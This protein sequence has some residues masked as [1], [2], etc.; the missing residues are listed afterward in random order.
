MKKLETRRP[1]FAQRDPWILTLV[2]LSFLSLSG[3]GGCDSAPSVKDTASTDQGTPI[4]VGNKPGGNPDT[5]NPP[6]GVGPTTPPA[7]PSEVKNVILLVGSGM[8]PQQIGEVVQYRRLRKPIED[9]LALEQ[10]LDQRMMGM[11]ATNSYLDIVTDTAAANTAMA[12]GLKARNNTVG[13]DPNGKPCTTVLEQAQALGKGTGVVSNARLSGPGVAPYLAHHIASEE[14]NEIATKIFADP[15][16]DVL[17]AGGAER[18]LPQN[19]ATAQLSVQDRAKI[20][21]SVIDRLPDRVIDI[22]PGVFVPVT[23]GA[24]PNAM[25]LS[26]LSECS[27]LDPALDGASRREDQSNLIENAKS[28]GYQFVCKGAALA[29][30]PA[31]ADTKLL[32]LFS[33]GSFPRS[34]DRRGLSDLPSLADLTRKAIEV[35]DKK[36]NGFLLVVQG[37]LTDQVARENDAGTLLQE[38]LDFDAALKAALE[39]AGSRNDTLVLVTSDHETGGFGF[40]Y[41]KGRGSELTLPSGDHYDAPYD[42]APA[43][44]YDALIE[45]KKSFYKMTWEVAEKLYATGSSLGLEEAGQMLV[46]DFQANTPFKLNLNQAKMVLEKAPGAD[47]AQ[48]LDF[49]QFYVGD[50]V[51]ANLLGRATATQTSAVWASGTSTSTPV[52]ILASGPVRYADQVRGFID[53]SDIGKIIA[54]ALAGR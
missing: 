6:P 37:G 25:K 51:H 18:L 22:D 43:T 19:K 14:E 8:G 1:F 5:G 54:K 29:E 2:L 52:L 45:Q 31:A 3:F 46:D 4:Q 20:T 9:K 47:S 13:L 12:C 41:A 15:K 42:Y 23:P 49:P 21:G 26:D 30:I 50:N 39:Y 17:L 11:V 53:N 48:T 33:A 34:P 38:G 7:Q 27:G 35:L 32:G 36:P 40:A 28:K 16:V 10:L 44:R 24:N